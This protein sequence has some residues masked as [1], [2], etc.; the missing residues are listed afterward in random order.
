MT[1]PSKCFYREDRVPGD[2]KC[3][4]GLPGPMLECEEHQAPTKVAPPPVDEAY[5]A[6][7]KGFK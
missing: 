3:F 1:C 6:K 7:W 2:G 5:L 4:L